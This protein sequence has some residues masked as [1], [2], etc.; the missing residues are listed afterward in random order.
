MRPIRPRGEY[1][2]RTRVYHRRMR[3]LFLVAVLLVGCSGAGTSF[4][5]V[6][7]GDRDAGSSAQDGDA[8][9]AE[10]ATAD[11]TTSTEAGEDADA[12]SS[13]DALAEVAPDADGGVDASDDADAADAAEPA[14]VRKTSLD[15]VC[16]AR[17]DGRNRGF[18]C[19][20]PDGSPLPTC[21]ACAAVDD[22]A[23][24]EWCGP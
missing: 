18:F 19:D 10:D 13:S 2:A 21:F 16:Q 14:C 3:R 5:V 22:A 20:A 9:A 8:R 4:L 23:S 7:D 24:K 6:V 17:G 12:T 11:G 15:V 1:A